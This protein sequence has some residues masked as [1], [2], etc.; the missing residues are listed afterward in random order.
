MALIGGPLPIEETQPVI[1][2]R[3]KFTFADTVIE[4]NAQPAYPFNGVYQCNV[5]QTVTLTASIHDLAGNLQ[6]NV[7]YLFPAEHPYAG[8]PIPLKLPLRKFAGN[9]E[10]LEEIYFATTIVDGVVNFEGVFPT[11]GNW[12]I[13]LSRV[14]ESLEFI[15]APFVFV[16]PD[17]VFLV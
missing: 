13:V 7:T 4:I 11:S 16:H 3:Y 17:V 14:N 12:R 8:V 10:T 2:T 15:Q 9:V 1:D 5:G 6:D